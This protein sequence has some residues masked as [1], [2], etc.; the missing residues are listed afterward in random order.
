M[1]EV[2][3]EL[4]NILQGGIEVFN[5]ALGQ[6]KNIDEAGNVVFKLFNV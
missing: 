2:K 4:Q 5:E 6:G 3:K 1:L